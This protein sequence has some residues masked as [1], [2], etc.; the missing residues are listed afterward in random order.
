M[1]MRYRIRIFSADPLNG[2]TTYTDRF[3]VAQSH[4][5][6]CALAKRALADFP[7]WVQYDVGPASFD[8][9]HD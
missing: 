6:A 1:I 3:K 8:A 5:E 7:L 2:A 4:S 9:C